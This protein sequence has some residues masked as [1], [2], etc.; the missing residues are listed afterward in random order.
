M[1]DGRGV[2]VVAFADS[3]LFGERGFEKLHRAL[4]HATSNV[5]VGK[6]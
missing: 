2:F 1:V 6:P 5:T 3:D 4:D